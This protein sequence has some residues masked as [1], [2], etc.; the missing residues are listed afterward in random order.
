[1]GGTRLHPFRNCFV[2][3]YGATPN[4]QW[5]TLLLCA[6]KKYNTIISICCKPWWMGLFNCK[7]LRSHSLP[8]LKSLAALV[9]SRAACR[10]V[11][12]GG[13]LTLG[14]PRTAAGPVGQ[15]FATLLRR[16]NNLIA[17]AQSAPAQ[18]HRTSDVSRLQQPSLAWTRAHLHWT[19]PTMLE[20]SNV[21]TRRL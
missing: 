12:S 7:Q 21:E 9:M 20:A 16:Q 17:A 4:Q 19:T 3:W 11:P 10:N 1:V 8:R 6:F 15:G 5:T 18:N 2:W 13:S 14:P